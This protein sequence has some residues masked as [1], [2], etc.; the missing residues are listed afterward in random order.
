MCEMKIIYTAHNVPEADC[1][2]MMIEAHEIPCHI[3]GSHHRSMLGMM[4]TFVEL[5][6]MVPASAVEEAL[7]LIKEWQEAEPED[8][9]T[10]KAT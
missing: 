8:G 3:Q 7:Q 2:K 10:I 1:I 6:I 4:G 5:N 9:E